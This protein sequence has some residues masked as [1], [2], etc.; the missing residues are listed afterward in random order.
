[1][2]A[3]TVVP[4]SA[5]LLASLTGLVASG[6]AAGGVGALATA[7][8]DAVTPVGTTVEVAALSSS[9]VHDG[10]A[11]NASAVKASAVPVVRKMQTSLETTAE[12]KS[13]TLPGASSWTSSASGAQF[14]SSYRDV[15]E[16]W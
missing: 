13:R 11:I 14:R 5:G 2:P 9:S 4:P 8:V 1:V 7:D 12:R 15:A 16:C 3:A 6:E 10:A